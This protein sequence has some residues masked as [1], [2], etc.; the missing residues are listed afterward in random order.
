MSSFTPFLKF[1][2]TILLLD[3][4]FPTHLL[5][6]LGLIASTT[7]DLGTVAAS[8]HDLNGLFSLNYSRQSHSE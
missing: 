8:S 3:P 6:D 5:E 7:L 4:A 1:V 2:R